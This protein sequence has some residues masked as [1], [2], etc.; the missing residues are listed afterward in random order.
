MQVGKDQLRAVAVRM[1]TDGL[2][3]AEALS[4]EAWQDKRMAVMMAGP[5][6]LALHGAADGKLK[7]AARIR[8]MCVLIGAAHGIGPKKIGR[9]QQLPADRMGVQVGR[10]RNNRR[11]IHEG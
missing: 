11:V 5:E 4:G 10:T 6:A 7:K 8:H 1:V 9:E 2:R 3:R